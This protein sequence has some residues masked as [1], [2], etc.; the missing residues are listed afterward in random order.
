MSA[1]RSLSR[2][3]RQI[4]G[5]KYGETLGHQDWGAFLDRIG[6]SELINYWDKTRPAIYFSAE[7][8]LPACAAD[9]GLGALSRDHF[10]QAVELEQ[11]SIFF[12]LAY[13]HRKTQEIIHDGY[14]GYEQDVLIEAL[15]S[16]EDVGMELFDRVKVN[17]ALGESVIPAYRY[18]VGT[19]ET[20][21]IL[22]Q[23][24][25][26]VYPQEVGSDARLWNNAVMGFGGYQVV[27]HLRELGLIEEPAYIHLNESATVLGALAALDD[28]TASLGD[29]EDALSLAMIYLRDKT[30]LTNHTLVPAAEATFSRKQVED[31]I[32]SNLK[33]SS[34]RNELSLLMNE[35]GG[36]LVLLELALLLSGRYNGVSELHSRKAV[37][38]FQNRY[39]GHFYNRPIEFTA[40]TNGIYEHGWNPEMTNFL[41]SKGVLDQF[42]M[43]SLYLDQ[44]LQTLEVD[45]LWNIKREAVVGLREYLATGTRRDHFGGVITL[46]EDAIVVGDARRF[47]DYKRRGIMFTD[48]DRLEKI[49][50]EHP[51]AHI[52]I[53]GKA[54]PKDTVAIPQ[55][56]QV[57]A[58][59]G[60]RDI[61]KERIH[62]LP[63]WDVE[64]AKMLTPAC[65]VWIN[66]PIVGKEACGTSG[67]KAALGGS[68]LVSTIDGFLAELDEKSFHSI[69]G[70]TN[71]QE[72][73]DSYYS[74]LEAA[75]SD[76]EGKEVYLEKLINLW[77][78][79]VLDR[80]SGARMLG[81]YVYLGVPQGEK[82]P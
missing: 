72:E 66:N 52:F 14:G 16:P 12:G 47:A 22:L 30:V 5:L 74:K 77:Q 82:I 81:E 70:E 67:Y 28:I 32:F 42:G 18:S 2:V 29:N 23:V 48:P 41:I 50:R 43:P 57:L 58:N 63:D 20:K 65:S 26:E 34:V 60:S 69:H 1:E 19:E 40:V 76:A 35:R 45:E 53:S 21:L 79:G 61:F 75:L 6:R 24:Q 17:G 80:L 59:I 7:Y 55:L 4:E 10:L 62:F 15:P 25:G 56:K 9:G 38:V 44:A 51:K 39:G 78:G 3:N 49:L 64:M 36:N 13:S 54:H 31:F 46:P 71:S 73:F 8:M 11:P 33:S 27:K 37:E 68:L